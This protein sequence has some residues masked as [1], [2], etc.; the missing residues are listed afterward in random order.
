MVTLLPV[1]TERSMYLASTSSIL[2]SEAILQLFGAYYM[3]VGANYAR[4]QKFYLIGHLVGSWYAK[5]AMIMYVGAILWLVFV[6]YVIMVLISRIGDV[7][8]IIELVGKYSRDSR[9]F[10]Q[11]GRPA[12]NLE[13][14]VLRGVKSSMTT[15]GGAG[16]SREIKIFQDELSQIIDTQITEW[17]EVFTLWKQVPN[18]IKRQAKD[19]EKE[20]KNIKW[21]V[22]QAKKGLKGTE[23]GEEE[24]SK[25][26]QALQVAEQVEIEIEDRWLND[27]KTRQDQLE[28]HIADIQQQ[29]ASDKNRQDE[30]RELWETHLTDLRIIGKDQQLFH[31]RSQAADL[32]FLLGNWETVLDCKH[33]LQQVWT[34]IKSKY[35]HDLQMTSKLQKEKFVLEISRFT[36]VFAMLICWSAQWLWWAGY[37]VIAG[38]GYCPPKLPQLAAIWTTFSAIGIFHIGSTI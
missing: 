19:R 11:E 23:E 27:T 14:K 16:Q 22:I 8:N 38:D 4:R 6:I 35:L 32:R 1:Q 15:R 28:A 20:S 18:E 2:F 13:I 7:S 3:G 9:G 33:R 34:G 12:T 25:W 21:Q 30:I 5:R 17:E 36:V 31:S 10:A 37:V 24:H 26:S 29:V